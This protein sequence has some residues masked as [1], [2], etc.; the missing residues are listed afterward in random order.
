MASAWGPGMSPN[1][2]SSNFTFEIVCMLTSRRPIRARAAITAV[3]LIA[4]SSSFFWMM[5]HRA[6]AVGRIVRK[7]G[8]GVGSVAVRTVGRPRRRS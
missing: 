2:R 3:G 4:S 7:S 1:R 6:T 8:G 5:Y